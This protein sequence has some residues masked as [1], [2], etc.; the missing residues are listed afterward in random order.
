MSERSHKRKR[1]LQDSPVDLS[2][3][4][5]ALIRLDVLKSELDGIQETE[6]ELDSI[7]KHVSALE[8]ILRGAKKP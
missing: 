8:D 3:M 4:T 1:S 2:K 5:M 6:E 7:T